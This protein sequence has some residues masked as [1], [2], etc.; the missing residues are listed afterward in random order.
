MTAPKKPAPHKAPIK[1]RVAS[2][3]EKLRSSGQTAT[4]KAAEG[5]EDFPVAALLGGL[6]LGAVVGAL[7]PR[8]RQEE[9]LLGSLGESLNERAKD[10]ALAARDAGQAKLDELGISGDAAGKQVGKL[11]ESIAQV[12]ETAGSAAVEAARH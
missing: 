9:Q 5:V 1:Q 2:A 7:L 11:I 10:A 3:G 8:T 4:R 12:A 6:A